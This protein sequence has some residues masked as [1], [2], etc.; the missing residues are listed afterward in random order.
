MSVFNSSPLNSAP[1][2][3]AQAVVI[4][5][6]GSGEI[7][8]FEQSVGLIGSGE[9]ISFEQSVGLL[10]KGSGKIISFE[11]VLEAEGVGK[12]ISF[13]Q[14]VTNLASN[15]FYQR[16]GFD[17]NINIGGY[18]VPKSQIHGSIEIDKTTGGSTS[19]KFTLIPGTGTQD[20]E[21]FQGKEVYVD[22]LKNNISHR[23]FT[24]F[25]DLPSLDIIDKKISFDCTDRRI[26]RINNLTRNII[27]QVG[28]YSTHVFGESEDLNEELG[29]R[30]QTV[31]GD[32]DFDSYG[33]Y[34]LT[35]WTPKSTADFTL[36]GGDVY[37]EKP[38]VSY[39][40]RTQTLN[41]VSFTIDYSYQRL[42]QQAINL[43]WTGYQ[44]LS[45]WYNQGLPSFPAREMIENSAREGTWRPIT[46][47]THTPLWEAQGFAS[48]DGA[49]TWQPNQIEHEYKARTKYV[50]VK[51][52]G[53]GTSKVEVPVLDVNGKKIY[54]VVRT[55]VTDTSSH[56]TRSA[57]WRAGIK[58]A[59]NVTERY[60]VTLKS[61]QAV[62]RYGII[63]SNE[64]I[65]IV[66]PYDTNSWENS[67]TGM[68]LVNYNF[69][70]N[71]K[72]NY[73]DLGKAFQVMLNKA[74]VD[75]LE[76]HRD[77]IVKF[78]RDLWPNI[79][80]KHTV[81]LD[82]T[83]LACKGKVS[84]IKHRINAS[85]GEASTYI[86]LKLSRAQSTDSDDSW[87]ILIPPSEDPGYVGG[88]QDIPLQ[89]HVG[90]DPDPDE[91]TGA[92]SW[93]G[94]IGNANITTTQANNTVKYRTGYVEQF[95][96]DYPGISDLLR[97]TRILDDDY[98]F[99][100]AVPNDPLTV[101]F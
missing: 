26:N 52:A 100:V 55:I 31:S 19:C 11:Q 64:D 47:I 38:E 69:F 56:L 90:I 42:H 10:Y 21:S 32:F 89:T 7:V 9:L 43:T 2:N 77:V 15:T 25:V 59:Q 93:N 88:V 14:S 63:D 6:T 4:I 45:S 48:N 73:Q 37:Y 27:D 39:T 5:G 65:D 50:W 98:S 49:V 67:E 53:G 54:D 8:S 91:T 86:E 40:N 87:S 41:T 83:P 30:L 76:A 92:D 82:T 61:P 95:R 23:Q 34:Q 72:T 36:D 97:Q 12:I 101:T 78:T 66:A 35:P 58:F 33:N 22:I 17:V 79:D 29:K 57:T 85:T 44:S 81:E 3:A 46:Q 68:Y 13:E 74:R 51:L 62:T 28:S 94:Y 16:N 24:G 96:V 75:I 71:K 80:L 60:N 99:D 1:L 18:I 20:P 70:I 84:I